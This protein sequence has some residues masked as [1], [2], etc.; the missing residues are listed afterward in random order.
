MVSASVPPEPGCSEDRL[1]STRISKQDE[2]CQMSLSFNSCIPLGR[3]DF[4]L[5]AFIPSKLH[6]CSL[7]SCTCLVVKTFYVKLLFSLAQEFEKQS[8][9]R[10]RARLDSSS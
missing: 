10:R 6:L 8:N 7:S 1:I 3:F 2:S 9:P 5:P 4:D